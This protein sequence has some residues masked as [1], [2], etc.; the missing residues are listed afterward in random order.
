MVS[1]IRNVLNKLL[2]FRSYKMIKNKVTMNGEKYLFRRSSSV[3]L[4]F[5]SSKSDIIL[6]DNIWMLGT[7]SS[8]NNG[9][10]LI[11]N[12]VKT[13]VNC[14]IA[15]V[16]F[17]SIGDF[18]AIADNVRII[19]NNNHPINPLDREFMRLTPENSEYRSWKYSNSAPI[20]IGK[21]CWIGEYVRICKGVT[22]GDNSVIAANSVV[23]K[24]VPSNCIAAGNPAKIVKTDIDKIER[25]FKDEN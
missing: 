19:D 2:D 23:T 11:G 18:T 3:S 24:N 14:L 1:I 21:N 16:N 10:I 5:G 4:M 17:I 22:I 25:I 8:Q 7:L 15:S 20:N 13:G 6:G 12:N 9:K